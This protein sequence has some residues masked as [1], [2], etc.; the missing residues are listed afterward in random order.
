MLFRSGRLIEETVKSV[1]RSQT[2]DD[3]Y[4][5]KLYEDTVSLYRLDQLQRQNR[6]ASGGKT[7][8]GPLPGTSV[9]LLASLAGIWV[10]IIV[11]VFA[12]K[13]KKTE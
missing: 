10:L 6:S 13:R 12:R 3:A 7:D 2:V 8:L 4:F 5:E 11:Y 1:R 9:A